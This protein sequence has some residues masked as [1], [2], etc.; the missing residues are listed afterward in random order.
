MIAL[1]GYIISTQVKTDF[2]E[3]TQYI[4]IEL[5]PVAAFGNDESNISV[6][7]LIA[8]ELVVTAGNQYRILVSGV[9]RVPR[10]CVRVTRGL[11]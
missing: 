11:N 3:G 2:V 5:A 7:E 6:G 1:K 4:V 8:S 10:K 9:N